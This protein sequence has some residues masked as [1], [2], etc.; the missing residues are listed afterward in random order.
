MVE[1]KEG[2]AVTQQ[3]KKALGYTLKPSS[4]KKLQAKVTTP[5]AEIDEQKKAPILEELTAYIAAASTP[6]KHSS[7]SLAPNHLHIADGVKLQGIL[8]QKCKSQ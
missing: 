4:R 2:K 8:K 7:P 3:Q 5:Q 6:T 1:N